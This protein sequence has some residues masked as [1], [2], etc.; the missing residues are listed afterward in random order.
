MWSGALCSTKGRT[1]RRC[2]TAWSRLYRGLAAMF[3]YFIFFFPSQANGR[4]VAYIGVLLGL[5]CF[6]LNSWA[7]TPP[8]LPA[9]MSQ[10]LTFLV[11]GGAHCAV[12]VDGD[13]MQ[14]LT[15]LQMQIRSADSEIW[16]YYDVTSS[17]EEAE[18]F[19]KDG[20]RIMFYLEK[21]SNTHE[22]QNAVYDRN[23]F[24]NVKVFIYIANVNFQIKFSNLQ[25]CLQK[26]SLH[27]RWADVQVFLDAPPR[28]PLLWSCLLAGASRDLYPARL[29]FA[30][31]LIPHPI[32]NGRDTGLSRC[33][34]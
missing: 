6:K 7:S 33:T 34:K 29:W 28:K 32:C 16:R 23:H 30:R 1:P 5:S 27:W 12:E 31:A 22:T 3:F 25:Q 18:V 11:E 10:T 13:N 17:T 9:T 2:H 26:P 19:W 8:P 20:G 24:L 14:K 15:Q 21:I 4:R